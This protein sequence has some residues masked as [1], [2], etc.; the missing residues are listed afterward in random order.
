MLKSH[1]YILSVQKASAVSILIKSDVELLNIS[2]NKD[3]RIYRQVIFKDTTFSSAQSLSHVQLFV[4]P[5]T[6]ALQASLS[7]TNSQSLLKLTVHWV[8]DAIKS[9]HP[10]SSP[11]PPAF[12]L[13]QH[14][15]FSQWLGSSHQM[16]KVLELQLQISPCNEYLGLICF[17][18]DWFD[19][20]AV[21]GTLKSLLH[22]HSSKASILWHSA[23]YIYC[24]E[25]CYSVNFFPV[26][27]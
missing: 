17:R 5:W 20:L 22:H 21:Q 19:L 16:T 6:A 14:Q 2:R 11:S 23:F 26:R 13:S 12:N 18:I 1:C 4:T 7:I 10:L 15:G 24:M 27:L 25:R 8:S 9:S 3:V